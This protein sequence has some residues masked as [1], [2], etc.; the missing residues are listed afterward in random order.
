MSDE[1]VTKNMGKFLREGAALLNIA[2]PQCNTPLLR[3]R[4][5]TMYCAKCNQQVV[6]QKTAKSSTSH[7]GGNVLNVLA[8]RTLSILESLIQSLPERPHP[9]EIRV[10]AKAARDLVEILQ[11]IQKLQS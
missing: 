10:F 5:G 1:N 11:G 2:C 6:E 3:L 9:E 4:D 8:T 7:E